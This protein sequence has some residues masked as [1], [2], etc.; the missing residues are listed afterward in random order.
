MAQ[1]HPLGEIVGQVM[2]ARDALGEW[3]AAANGS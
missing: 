1:P 3:S 2:L